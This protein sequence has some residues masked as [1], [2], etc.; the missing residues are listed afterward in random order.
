MRTALI[1]VLAFAA[2]AAHAQQPS[3][4]PTVLTG[5]FQALPLEDIDLAIRVLPV[6]SQSL[7]LGSLADVLK[8]DPSVDVQEWAPAGV[9]AGV[10]IRGAGFSR[11]LVL[12]NGLRLN[13]VQSARFDMGLPAPLDAVSKVEVLRGAASALYGSDAEGGVVNVISEPPPGDEFRLRTAMGNQGINQQAASAAFGGRRFSEQLSFARD[14]SSGF[15][16]DRDYRNL[17]F[18]SSTRLET[19]LGTTGIAAAYTDHP[20]GAAEF[21]GAPNSW[22]DS[23]T[24][25]AG[26]QQQIGGPTT[27]SVGFRRH[28][29]LFVLDRDQPGTSAAHNADETLQLGLRRGQELSASATLFYGVETLHESVAGSLGRHSRTREAVYGAFVL[30]VPKRFFLSISTREEIYG[31]L[32]SALAPAVSGALWL[33]PKLKLRAS[34]SRAFRIANYSELYEQSPVALG[35]PG[36]LP[37]RSWTYEAGRDWVPSSKVRGDLTLFQRRLQ[38]G[39]DYYRATPAD[40]WRAMNLPNLTFTGVEAALHVAPARWQSFDFRYT[41]LEGLQSTLPMSATLY[42]ANYAANSAVATWQANPKGN[43]ILRTRLGLADRRTRDAYALWDLYLALSRGKVHPFL[44]FSNLANTSYQEVLGVAM[45]G[46]TV[47]GGVDLVFR[48]R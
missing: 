36:L 4:Q 39:I 7:V 18:A 25:F 16:P 28:S 29:D 35:S 37:E 32:S 48:K 40:L 17:Q 45:P 13:S 22:E 41:W 23:K 8:L 2:V 43:F 3:P 14:F 15:Q 34:G 46:R 20:F 24:W 19:K 21:Y 9:Q 47:I 38:D 33:S 30:R 27:A 5:S 31:S 42:S 11:T 1:P 12:W 10:S 44:Q 6:R 26:L